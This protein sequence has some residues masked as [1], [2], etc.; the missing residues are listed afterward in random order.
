MPVYFLTNSVIYI[1]SIIHLK[2]ENNIICFDKSK[3]LCS[4]TIN[5]IFFSKTGTLCENN[6][7]IDSFHPTYITSY[8][9]NNIS[10]KTFKAEQHKEI[11][12]QLLQYYKDYLYKTQ[13]NNQDFDVRRPFRGDIKKKNK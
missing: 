11:N 5:T 8:K 9:S 13:I 3:L 7:E 4:S 12:L 10:Y 2:K 6:F 1:V